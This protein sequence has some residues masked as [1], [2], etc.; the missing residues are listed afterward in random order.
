MKS[1]FGDENS[2]YLNSINAYTHIPVLLKE[3]ID[4][5]NV[6]E[7]GKY[8]DC[9]AGGGGYT[10][11]IT[12]RGG[13]VMAFDMDPDA[14]SFLTEK[15]RRNPLVKLEHANF[16]EVKR[17]ADKNNYLPVA[18]IV[19]DLGIS[20]YQLE[21][22]GRGFSFMKDE[23]LDMRMDSSTGI[24]AFEIINKWTKEELYELFSRMGEERFARPISDRIVRARGVKPIV[25]TKDLADIVAEEVT[26]S[27]MVHPATKVFQAVRIAVNDEIGS[28]KKG[29]MDSFEILE[30][31]GR[32]AVVSFHSLEDRIVKNYF[33]KVAHAGLGTIITKKPV[34]P[35]NDELR[36]NKRSRSAK[37]RVIEKK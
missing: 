35:D 24:N 19:Y 28:L 8:I 33:K 15:F 29:L 34:V 3:V 6:R 1:D 17:Y 7:G 36:V 21:R 25:T 10:E 4:L 13:S 9:T 16:S 20:S 14:I 27:R 26:E 30:E 5:I 11:A 22:S 23:E 32:M 2:R 31:K 12:G 18:G 37:L